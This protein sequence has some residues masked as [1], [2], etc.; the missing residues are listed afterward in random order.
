[1][2]QKPLIARLSG[3]KRILAGHPWLFHDDL[4]TSPQ[5]GNGDV[6]SLSDERGGFLGRG[7][8]NSNSRIAFRLITRADQP[9]DEKFW[10]GRLEDAIQ[11]REAMDPDSNARR[12]VYSEADG[13]PGLIIDDYGGHLSLQIL[14]L[15]IEKLKELILATLHERLQPKAI[16]LRNDSMVRELEGLTQEKAV[17]HGEVPG[18]IEIRE[19]DLRFRVNLLEG[20]KTGAYLDQ[21]DNR[22]HLRQFAAGKRILDAFCYEGWFGLHLARAGASEVLALDSSQKALDHATANSSANSLAD[23]VR[24]VRKNCFDELK[25]MAVSGNERFDL[26]VLDPP[27]F[28]R[29]KSDIPNALRAYRE[30]NR[31]AIQCLNP[32]GMLFSCCCSHGV[33]QD[34]FAGAIAEAAGKARRKLLLLEQRL[35]APDHPILFNEPESLYLKGLLFRCI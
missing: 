34:R 20:Q 16:V 6:F 7:F 17:H 5:E 18:P 14:S 35:Q 21:R 22:L 10:K 23:R 29:K 11:L 27:P 25:K 12:L 13:F 8:Y 31:R 28:A 33:S 3:T 4:K 19:G 30:I 1:M 24:T 26:I 32:G 9:V 15:G 2:I